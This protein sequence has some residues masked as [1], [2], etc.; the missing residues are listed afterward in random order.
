MSIAS[1][2]LF[3][4][5]LFPGG[6]KVSKKKNDFEL[7]LHQFSIK[8]LV[9]PFLNQADP[10]APGE[11]VQF[12]MK[13]TEPIVPC[14]G[15]DS[16]L[17]ILIKVLGKE[18]F[19]ER[20]ARMVIRGGKLI[21]I[22]EPEL[23]KQIGPLL[24][25]MERVIAPRIQVNCRLV[26]A[27]KKSDFR[28][29]DSKGV[30]KYPL[31]FEGR[32]AGR[33]GDRICFGLGGEKIY[34]RS[35]SAEV[36]QESTIM[37]PKV[38]SLPVGR[39]ISLLA[40]PVPNGEGFGV[41]GYYL[42]RDENAEITSKDLAGKGLGAME[43]SEQRVLKR[44]FSCKV[45]SG[46]SVFIPLG[47]PE[48]LGLILQVQRKDP[49]PKNEGFLFRSMSLFSLPL[50]IYSPSLFRPSFA[51]SRDGEEEKEKDFE[52]QDWM[53]DFFDPDDLFHL[54]STTLDRE[55]LNLELIGGG[56]NPVFYVSGPNGVD[57]KAAQ[58]LDFLTQ[59][60]GRSFLVDVSLQARPRDNS[61]GEWKTIR[62]VA[63]LP[64]LSNRSILVETGTEKGY[65]KDYE[66]EIAQK[67]S[68]G[69]PIPG[70]I[71]M[72]DRFRAFLT[73]DREDVHLFLTLGR[74]DLLGFRRM[75]PACDKLGPLMAPDI[76]RVV[77]RRG[78]SLKVGE[79]IILGDGLP[80][81]IDGL[82]ECRT[83]YTMTVRE[84]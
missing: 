66:V 56:E 24:E 30:S 59:N 11:E 63:S 17:S 71:F 79:E 4:P 51:S 34:Q 23:A 55:G 7:K 12:G 72:G 6:E 48:N 32:E 60:L 10:N 54:L 45:A 62:K 14:G 29:L 73:A 5:L 38:H 1:L 41:F 84:L 26:L 47:G 82:G 70:K 40:L 68:I 15:A 27:G 21:F 35:L 75:P 39:T 61:T 78:F 13:V 44:A 22:G 67:A 46:S 8:R 69:T 31:L 53:K 3:I 43:F 18:K 25:R 83:R 65:L 42:D 28:V 33:A 37:D 49:L 19:Q 2:T 52:S 77:F 9:M 20:K 74:Q 50:G 76:R 36:A 57:Q 80:A 58:V 16:L 81:V 64:C